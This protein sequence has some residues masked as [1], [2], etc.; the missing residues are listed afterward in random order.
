[1]IDIKTLIERFNALK[2]KEQYLIIGLICALIF[3]FYFNL[4]FNPFNAK[5][6]RIKTE[7]KSIKTKISSI[8]AE[9]PTVSTEEK[10]LNDLK[11][12]YDKTRKKLYD[13]E[14][15]LTNRE[16]IPRILS[17]LIKQGSAYGIDFISIKPTAT[18]GKATYSK[19]EIEIKM[20][21]T[22]D[23]FVNYLYRLENISKFLKPEKLEL[24]EIKN[25]MQGDIKCKVI[26]STFLSERPSENTEEIKIPY[27]ERLNIER[28]PFK[29]K[30]MPKK[31]GVEKIEKKYV[32]QGVNW[33]GGI[34]TAVINGEVY[35]LGDKIDDLYVSDITKNSAILKSSTGEALTINLEYE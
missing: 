32:L 29:S 21:A 3:S 6:K 10:N 16:R 31:E 24:E 19:L 26:L 34:S 1:M 30:S 28:N 5:I 25:G 4:F 9:G 15:N 35:R 27:L 18:K 23:N 22:Y 2:K 14:D 7:V 13:I 12:E 11:I 20:N 33:M 8:K 17:E